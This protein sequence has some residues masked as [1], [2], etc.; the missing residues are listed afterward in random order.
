LPLNKI[1]PFLNYLSY[2]IDDF[3]PFYV[4]QQEQADFVGIRKAVENDY[5]SIYSKHFSTIGVGFKVVVPN[6][7]DV[8]SLETTPNEYGLAQN[9]PN[10]FNPST[11][12]SYTLPNSGFT[13]LSVYNSLGQEVQSLINDNQSAGTHTVNFNASNL[14]SGMYFYSLTSGNFTQTN[15]MI[16]MK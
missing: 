6:P 9:Y 16:L 12:I 13:K 15:K 8:N 10:P 5:L 2:S 7:T 4:D 14:P 11:T 1:N 3:T